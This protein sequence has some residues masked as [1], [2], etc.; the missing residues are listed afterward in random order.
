MV[1][2]QWMKGNIIFIKWNNWLAPHV[3]YPSVFVCY[4][5]N[6]LY[7]FFPFNLFPVLVLLSTSNSGSTCSCLSVWWKSLWFSH[8]FLQQHMSNATEILIGP[9]SPRLAV[10]SH[11]LVLQY[12]DPSINHSAAFGLTAEK[13]LPTALQKYLNQCLENSF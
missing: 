7:R 3:L 13:Q 1:E 9:A 4:D 10:R 12:W 11:F 2:I 8:S 5:S 6:T